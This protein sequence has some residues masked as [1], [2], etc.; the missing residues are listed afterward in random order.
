MRG[1]QSLLSEFGVELVAFRYQRLIVRKLFS[2]PEMLIGQW[3][4]GTCIPCVVDGYL[5]EG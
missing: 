1:A 5:K 2:Q 3:E 4:G